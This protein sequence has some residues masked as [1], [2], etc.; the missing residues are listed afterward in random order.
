MADGNAQGNCGSHGYAPN[1]KPIN[2]TGIRES[3]DVIG[4]ISYGNLVR[5]AKAG[6]PLP[7][8]FKGQ[9]ANA[10]TIRKHFRYLGFVAA[11]PVLKNY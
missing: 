10:L 2:A 1:D 7:A 5:I 4:E 9:T 3:Q 6:F 8:A 11:E